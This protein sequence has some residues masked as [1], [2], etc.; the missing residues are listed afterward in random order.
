MSS[1]NDKAARRPATPPAF[2]PQP[3]PKAG[4]P[5]AP[6][7]YRPGAS[8]SA[9]PKT[10]L[11]PPRLPTLPPVYRPQPQRIA[12]PRMASAQLPTVPKPCTP[13]APKPRFRGTAGRVIQPMICIVKTNLRHLEHWVRV[14]SILRNPKHKDEEVVVWDDL[15]DNK[16][17]RVQEGDRLALLGHGT[18]QYVG[19]GGVN[20]GAWNYDEN[21][22]EIDITKLAKKGRLPSDIKRIEL[23]SCESGVGDTNSL[24][25][26]LARRLGN[27][28]TVWGYRGSAFSTTSGKNR[29]TLDAQ[30]N[31]D[32]NDVLKDEMVT[33]DKLTAF[34]LKFNQIVDDIEQGRRPL[35]N[36]LVRET[37]KELESC[38]ND[39]S[40]E[41][42]SP[43]NILPEGR[44]IVEK[45]TGHVLVK[46][47]GGGTR[48]L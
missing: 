34:M 38:F 48:Q 1:I 14:D 5:V 17:M 8:K 2:R 35:S 29:A 12:Q 22:L 11:P 21:L 32:V 39:N 15:V 31:R 18:P 6:P 30:P 19:R 13:L 28:Y 10:A 26:R 16:S 42:E 37:V 44:L 36:A 7:V 40:P 4:H 25:V 43:H 27:K 45:G 41:V 23:L 20:G 24:A 9:Q 47:H 33:N 3:S 46:T